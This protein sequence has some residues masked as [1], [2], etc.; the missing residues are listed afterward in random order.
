[1]LRRTRLTALLGA[2]LFIGAF[3]GTASAATVT[4]D[5]TRIVY[6]ADAGIDQY[7]DFGDDGAGTVTIFSPDDP[8]ESFPANCTDTDDGTPPATNLSCT[9]VTGVTAFALDGDDELDGFDMSLPVVF[10]AGD[11]ADVAYGGTGDDQVFGREGNDGFIAGDAIGAGGEEG[12]ND[13][14]DGGPGDDFVAGGRGSD[15]VIGGDGAD[16]AVGG[17]GTDN[18]DGGTGDDGFVAGGPDNDV[19]SGGD[20]DDYVR[21]GCDG[22]C[23]GG[24][25]DAGDT[26]NG[27]AGSDNLAGEAGDDI[28]NGDAGDDFLAADWYD[29]S[30]AGNDA[31][32]GGDGID[33]ISYSSNSYDDDSPLA[34]NVT[35]DGQAN[36]GLA[37]EA[38]NVNADVEDIFVSG[39]FNVDDDGDATVLGGPGINSINTAG[40]NDTVDGGAGNDFVSTDGG[41]DT[42]NARDG[43][44]DRVTCGPDVDTANVDQFD[45]VAADC[46]TVNR[47]TVANAN[48]VPED[49]APAVSWVSPASGTTLS[50]RNANTLTVNA[51]DD[52][53]IARVV[54]LDDERIV[55]TDTVAPYTCEYRPQGDDVGRNT[56]VAVAIDTAQ[57]T[58]T[59]VRS[60]RVNRFVGRLTS[61]VR[62]RR[63][64]TD[65]Y[66]FTTTGRLNLPTGVTRAQGCKGRVSVQVKAGKKTVST[67]RVRLRS[68]CTYRSRVTFTIPRRLN[69]ERLQ[70][71]ARF[72]GNEVM[73]PRR[74]S[75]KRV[76]VRT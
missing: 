75:R 7:V 24:R 32:N 57:Q 51:S 36:D 47:A 39:D 18:V 42:I 38:D 58:A 37:G 56:L 35:A 27:G 4:S 14:A 43:F 61:R 26:V 13:L 1:M 25:A 63:D 5:G 20:G 71:V 11:G 76:T 29:A 15:T 59:A 72:L 10:D 12:G 64:T 33:T 28:V 46:E 9:G 52:R 19:V 62:P 21:G 30:E 3:A 67:R 73:A 41:D 70:V 17:P 40:G 55:C 66:R 50:N 74:A 48:D 8:I 60:V 45:Q 68:D 49:A 2:G 34:V 23:G 69:P 22:T 54:F 6:T 65:P 16:G 44:A 53:G 31:W